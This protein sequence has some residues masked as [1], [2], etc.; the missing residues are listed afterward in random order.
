MEP[1]STVGPARSTPTL[2]RMHLVDQAV[3]YV[4][5]LIGNGEVTKGGRRSSEA[6]LGRNWA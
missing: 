2:R 3:D 5:R 4:R 6:A 1:E